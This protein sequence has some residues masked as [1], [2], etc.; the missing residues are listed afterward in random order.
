MRSLNTADSNWVEA[1]RGSEQFVEITP[2]H[3]I[4]I[5]L[6]YAGKNNFLGEELYPIGAVCFFTPR[7][8]S[9]FIL[10]SKTFAQKLS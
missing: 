3:R 1:V 10:G 8:C 9:L 5:N 4:A 2:D 6:R 7:G